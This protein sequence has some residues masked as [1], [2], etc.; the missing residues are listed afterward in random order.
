MVN[1]GV[2]LIKSGFWALFALILCCCACACMTAAPPTDGQT[3]GS[4]LD[5][6][7][8]TP[9]DEP[10][11][12]SFEDAWQEL[13][14]YEYSGSVNLTGLT[15]HQVHGIGVA[16][17]GTADTWIVGVQKEETSSLL[18]YDR[19]SW[20]QIAWK[21]AFTQ[22]MITFDN[23]ALPSQ[24]YQANQKKIGDIMN[25]SGTE[26]SN[27]DLS[28]GIYTISIP[29]STGLSMIRFNASTGEL[30]SDIV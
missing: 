5:I 24:I 15:L 19:E 28:D 30:L 3:D 18:V 27:M 4:G 22:K 13:P 20:S 11:K 23:I 12:V 25:A 9:R 7:D 16:I 6:I 1:S 17:N 2:I 10:A 29:S 8:K 14:D 26:V 21:E